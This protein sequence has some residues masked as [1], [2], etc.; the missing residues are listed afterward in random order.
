MEMGID[1]G[2]GTLKPLEKSMINIVSIGLGAKGKDYEN[3]I[4]FLSIFFIK[5]CG[6]RKYDCFNRYMERYMLDEEDLT[7]TEAEEMCS[8]L[9]DY[10]H[11][12]TTE[13][14]NDTLADVIA[15]LAKNDILSIDEALNLFK[16][17]EEDREHIRTEIEKRLQAQNNNAA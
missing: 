2:D 17:T 11:R 16:V 12:Y 10:K 5:G 13:G 4:D 6:A 15:I 9:E 3:I 14:K 1:R 7:Y 8:L